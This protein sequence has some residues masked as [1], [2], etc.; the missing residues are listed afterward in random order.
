MEIILFFHTTAGEPNTFAFLENFLYKFSCL[1]F[2]LF[3]YAAGIN[4]NGTITLYLN[5]VEQTATQSG[6]YTM[7]AQ[8]RIGQGT[9]A[10]ANFLDGDVNNFMIFNRALT[11]EEITE[12]Y[13]AG[14][15]AYTPV[16]NSLVAQ[17]SGRDFAGTEANPTTIYDTN[18]L[19]PKLF[20]NVNSVNSKQ[21]DVNLTASDVGA[22]SFKIKT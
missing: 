4:N 14:K 8:F 20:N 15:D 5:G 21:G 12:I 18:H 11:Q 13:N 7:S 6:S 10:G 3:G 19:T 2:S 1:G 17:Y 22:V 16:T 9:S